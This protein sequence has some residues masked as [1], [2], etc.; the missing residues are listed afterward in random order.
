MTEEELKQKF[1]TFDADGTGKVQACEFKQLFKECGQEP[2]DVEIKVLFRMCEKDLNGTLSFE[3]FLLICQKA[4]NAT[5]EEQTRAFLQHLMK[6]GVVSF[7][8]PR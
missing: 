3:E 4:E 7:P 2:H 8:E 1:Q 5:K 6:M